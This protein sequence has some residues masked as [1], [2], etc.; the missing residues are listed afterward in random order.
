MKEKQKNGTMKVKVN[1][2][3][4][5]VIMIA[6]GVLFVIYPKASLGTLT[7]LLG[8]LILASGCF[9]ILFSLKAQKILPNASSSTLLGVFQIMLGSL[10]VLNHFGMLKDS[11][12]GVLFATWVMYEGLSLVIS[13]FGYKRATF[14]N[15]WVMLL[16]GLLNVVLGYVALLY[17]EQISTVLAVIV[18]LGIVGNGVMRI[19]AFI[20]IQRIEKRLKQQAEAVQEVMGENEEEK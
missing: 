10:F 1:L 6:V 8:V 5:A 9:T 12:I 3:L 18:G 13:S 4:T 20:A 19:V 15:W 14:G 16:F 11:A 2:I 17:A 7:W